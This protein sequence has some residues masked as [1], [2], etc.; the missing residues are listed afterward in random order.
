MKSVV[1]SHELH[2]VRKVGGVRPLSLHVSLYGGSLA[3]RF[4]KDG[5]FEKPAQD[6]SIGKIAD[7]RFEVHEVGE[8]LLLRNSQTVVVD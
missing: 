3:R 4:E 5:K 2:V 8:E 1:F 6:F 7:L